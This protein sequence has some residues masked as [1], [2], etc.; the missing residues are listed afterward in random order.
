MKKKIRNFFETGMILAIMLA[1]VMPGVATTTKPTLSE[2]ILEIPDAEFEWVPVDANGSH[3]IDGHEIILHETGQ[4]VTLEIHVSGW[5]PNLLEVLQATVDSSGYSNGVGGT[6]VPYGW[7][8]SPEDG[9]FIDTSRSDFV[10]YGLV[11][12]DAVYTGD[13]DYKWGAV[14]LFSS[15]A[16][17]G[18]TYYLGTLILEV[19]TDASG[20]Y[21]IDFIPGDANTFM[22]DDGGQ[23]ILP[24]TLTPAV[25]SINEPPN[26]PAKPSG[27]TNGKAGTSY[28]YSSTT[29]DPDGDQ[30]YYWF[31]WGD[32]TSSSW[33]GPYVS[34][35]PGNASHTWTLQGSYN[36][37]V[38]S[39]DVYGMESI[40]S[41]PLS[42]TMPKNKAFNFN[43]DLLDWLFER[44][45][46]AFPIL[47]YL[48]GL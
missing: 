1:F 8:G 43:F 16:D 33:V 29:T 15:K 28:T 48:L 35:A 10:F 9:C 18:Q 2:E 22:K 45:P 30:V 23:L 11:Y 47:K 7:P 5:Y 32:N 17:D 13:L 38:K 34:G 44:F 12:L 27:P 20:T 41:D 4:L 25:I 14:L 26:K 19:P 40:W 39:K 24:L 37:Q 42:V 6:L 36:I 3:T 31:D 46:N 21:T